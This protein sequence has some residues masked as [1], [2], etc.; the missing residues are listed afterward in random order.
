MYIALTTPLN[1]SPGSDEHQIL[2]GKVKKPVNYEILKQ[3]VTKCQK[4]SKFDKKSLET[5]SPLTK[6]R[7]LH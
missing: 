1:Q 4:Y 6:D 5:L 3:S 2:A 7:S